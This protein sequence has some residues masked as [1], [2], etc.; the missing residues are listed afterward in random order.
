MNTFNEAMRMTIA[1]EREISF[2]AS[3]NKV[4]IMIYSKA[5]NKRVSASIPITEFF[6]GPTI[7]AHIEQLHLRIK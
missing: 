3:Q 2:R 7:A 6:H 5:G 1:S 4:I